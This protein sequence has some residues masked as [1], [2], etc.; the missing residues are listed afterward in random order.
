MEERCRYIDELEE[1]ERKIRLN[2]Q[3]TE[4]GGKLGMEDNIESETAKTEGIE[5]RGIIDQTNPRQEVEETE[6][7]KSEEGERIKEE[8]GIN[9]T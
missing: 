2:E 5:E 9:Q 7:T 1:E 4:E 6:E 3:R 8:E